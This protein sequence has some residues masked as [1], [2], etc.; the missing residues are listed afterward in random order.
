MKKLIVA[1]IMVLASFGIFAQAGSQYFAILP[2]YSFSTGNY[3]ESTNFIYGN[4]WYEFRVNGSMSN[5]FVGSMDYG[6]FFTENVG[7]HAGYVYNAGQFHANV[8]VGPYYF[9]DYKFDRSINI[10]EIGPEFAGPVGTNGQLFFQVNVGYTFGNS[11]PNLHTAVR[12]LS[13]GR[14]RLR[15]LRLRRRH[16]LPLL[17]QQQRRHRHAGRLSPLPELPHQRQLG[18]PHR[19]DLQVL[20]PLSPENKKGG[21]S[22]PPFLL[23]PGSSGSAP[24][25][26]RSHLG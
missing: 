17:L 12:R 20:T 23:S 7:I 8:H 18:R 13:P 1:A 24:A 4:Q 2:G 21:P 25:V 22:G 11:T 10:F 14:F 6:Y 16:R 3:Q 9:G 26:V 5:N 19:R 15:D